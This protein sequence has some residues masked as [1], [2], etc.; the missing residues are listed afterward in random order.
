MGTLE[1]GH[2]PFERHPLACPADFEQPQHDL[3]FALFQDFDRKVFAGRLG[4]LLSCSPF[5][6]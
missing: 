6:V 4:R 1:L 3:A 2:K 5:I